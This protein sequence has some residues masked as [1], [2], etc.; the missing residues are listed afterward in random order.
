MLK[1]VVLISLLYSGISVAQGYRR[2]T[3][4]SA[5][6]RGKLYTK[7]KKVE[8]NGPDIGFILNQ[9]FVST[10]LVHAGITYYSSE[11]YGWQIEGAFGINSDKPERECIE[12]F[13]NNPAK[14]QL[15]TPC[16]DESIVAANSANVNW[17]PAYVPIREINLLVAGNMVWS[18]VYG[19]QLVFLSSVIHFDMFLT[20]GGGLAMSTFY[21]KSSEVVTSSGAVRPSRNA[22]PNAVGT[23]PEQLG[24]GCP[25]GDVDC[26]G[27]NGRPEAESQTNP[28]I[29]LGVGQKL[30]IN[31]FLHVKLELRNMTLVGTHSGFENLLALWGGVGF[32]F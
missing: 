24:I 29:N 13:Y 4:G 27:V 2:A 12:N 17:G 21:A 9:S 1:Y 19:K 8:V 11:E 14:L 30:H 23:T 20:A 18:P 3:E 7:R 26:Y 22:D 10:T 5:A 28:Y 25:L 31:K 32:R 6:V 15:E 16:N